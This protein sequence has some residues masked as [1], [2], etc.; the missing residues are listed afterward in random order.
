MKKRTLALI[1][2]VTMLLAVCLTGCGSKTPTAESTPNTTAAPANTTEAAAPSDEP[3]ELEFWTINLKKNFN[4]YIQGMIDDYEEEHP[5]ITINWVD[6]PGADV[7]QK[8]IT[9]MASDDVPDVINQ[10]MLGYASIKSK[11]V[12]TAISDYADESALSVYIP[13][14]CEPVTQDGKLMAIPW[15]NG[16]PFVQFVNTE[17]YEAAGLDPN[18]P[19]TNVDELLENGRIIYEKT[20]VYGSNDFPTLLIMQ[21]EG[22]DIVSEDGKTALF[23]SP[24]HVALLQKFIDAYQNGSLAPGCIGKDDR[25]YQE[26]FDSEQTA[27]IGWWYASI[28]NNWV[29][30]S[31]DFV[32]KVK[33]AP[34]ITGAGGS[35]PMKDSNLF[36]VPAKS[37]HPQEAVDFAL[38]I[39]SPER[40]LEFCEQVAIYP[41]TSE[42]L[43]DAYF[44]SIEGDTLSDDARRV[45]IASAKTVS[46]DC[47]TALDNAQQLNE[48][49]N[50]KVRAALMGTLTAQEALDQAAAEWNELLNK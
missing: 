37:E 8:M 45:M 19:P 33:V 4:D 41:S 44:Q 47:V 21:A 12:L 32:Q 27:Q 2:A 18:N 29:S 31:P 11:G 15:Y 22:L 23:N 39:T 5:N 40:Q 36:L 10:T 48:I 16:G 24:E 35:I 26:S 50:E 6:V 30:N 46:V 34:A 17:L 7:T 14:L 42:T 43:D 9:A 1:L 20:G 25:A 49:Y 13:G 28:I 38:Y 3:I